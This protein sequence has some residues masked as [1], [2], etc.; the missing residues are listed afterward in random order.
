MSIQILC[1]FMK[2]GLFSLLSSKSFF[3]YILDKSLVSFIICKYYLTLCELS[4]HFPYGI[5]WSTEV[6]NLKKYNL[7][8]IWYYYINHS[9]S[10]SFASSHVW[11]WERDYKENWVPENWCFWT[12]VL[13]KTLESPLD[14][15]EI[16]PVHL[17]GNQSWILNGKTDAEAEAPILWPPDTKN[18]LTGKCPDAGKDWRQEEK[19]M[20]ENERVGWHHQLNGHELE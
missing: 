11:M 10:Y 8:M 20:T 12:V 17:K 9:Q 16:Q 2:I 7:S 19:G 5:L 1:C 14:C 4:F 18:W 13:E 15:K 3:F 6:F